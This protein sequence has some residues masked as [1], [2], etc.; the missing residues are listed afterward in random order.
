MRPQSVE[1]KVTLAGGAAGDGVAALGLPQGDESRIVFCEDVTPATPAVPL[2][3]AAG[4]V[5]RVR[6]KSGRKGDSTIKLRPCRWSQ[7][8][9]AFAADRE[10]GGT[11]LKIEPDWA[12]PK[13]VLAASLTVD[14]D[15]DR[16][17]A[18]RDG[19]A[20]VAALFSPEQHA[21]LAECAAAPV[22]L[23]TVTPLADIH[24]TR[25]KTFAAE[26]AGRVL[27]VRAERWTIGTAI[28]FL[29]L[30][31]VSDV[32]SAERDQAALAEVVQRAGLRA[33]D[34]QESKTARVLG[35]LVTQSLAPAPA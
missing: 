14:W 3:L 18:V 22:N 25:W 5:L 33:D 2:L 17:D 28:D 12:G 34:A 7:L 26:A 23:A 31:V 4:V 13:R 21:F 10:A 11:E 9:A 35:H 24:A 32:E 20:P 1:I 29:E 27:D 19:A 6:R 30:S 15:D 16:L 8:S